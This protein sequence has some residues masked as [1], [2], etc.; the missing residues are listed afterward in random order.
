MTFTG[1]STEQLKSCVRDMETKWANV[2]IVELFTVRDNFRAEIARREGRTLC[3][4][5]DMCPICVDE[6][7]HDFTVKA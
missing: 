1:I 5:P 3:C 6:F 4:A 2:A 7:G